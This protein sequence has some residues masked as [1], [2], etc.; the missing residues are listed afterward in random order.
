MIIVESMRI[1]VPGF[2]ASR[3]QGEIALMAVQNYGHLIRSVQRKVHTFGEFAHTIS[4][5]Y[6]L[7]TP[8]NAEVVR[9]LK[10]LSHIN[11]ASD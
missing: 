7:R 8:Q 2:K 1:A 11:K 9:V 4:E 10:E 3:Y 6:D 5:H